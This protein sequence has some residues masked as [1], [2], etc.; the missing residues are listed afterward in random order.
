M[1][2]RLRYKLACF[3]QG[4]YGSDNFSQFL[5]IAALALLVLSW[6]PRL[7]LLSTLAFALLIYIY[8]RMFS[9]NIARRYQENQWFLRQKSRFIGFFRNFRYNASQRR[10][11]HIYRCPKC[12]QKIRVPRGKGR[13]MVRCPKCGTEFLKKS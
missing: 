1:L 10:I 7:G 11:Y 9:R 3:M 12:R 6:I 4:R 13:I 5:L 8:F 2:N